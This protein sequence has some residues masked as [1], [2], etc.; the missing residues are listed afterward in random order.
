MNSWIGQAHDLPRWIYGV[1]YLIASLITA[2]SLRRWA[3]PES[4]KDHDTAAAMLGLFLPAVAIAV[5]PIT[6]TMFRGI[7]PFIPAI[8]ALCA[9]G[10]VMK[11]VISLGRE[12]GGEG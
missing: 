3:M 7:A 10:L 8:V 1:A 4:H 5:A 12:H 9:F 11:W 6:I 2:Y